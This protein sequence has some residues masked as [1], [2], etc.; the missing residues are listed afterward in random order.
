MRQAILPW[1]LRTAH[2]RWPGNQTSV[3]LDWHYNSTQP[4][5]FVIENA[6]FQRNLYAFRTIHWIKTGKQGVDSL[7]A[8]PLKHMPLWGY[9]MYKGINT[10][11]SR[12]PSTVLPVELFKPLWFQRIYS[13][14]LTRA[15]QDR[16]PGWASVSCSKDQAGLGGPRWTPQDSGTLWH[17]QWWS[18]VVSHRWPSSLS[19][20]CKSILLPWVWSS[21]NQQIHMYPEVTDWLWWIP[22]L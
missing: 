18:Q 12:G 9:Q 17:H 1:S 15:V 22:L 21:S 5:H 6:E 2:N 7:S 19:C 20:Y 3:G 8:F 4:S 14:R 10:L 13:L 11:D 16:H